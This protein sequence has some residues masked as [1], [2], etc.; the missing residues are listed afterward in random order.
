M[1]NIE[2]IYALQANTTPSVNVKGTG[3]TLGLT[4]SSG[5]VGLIGYISGYNFITTSS[6]AYN[7]SI[8]TGYSATGNVNGSSYG[9][10]TDSTKSGLV[11][12]T[13]NL[14]TVEFKAVIKY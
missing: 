8:T 11:T 4:N 3:K 7:N 10:T 12:T 5:N 9:V 2:T 13:G 6:N 1:P 14:T